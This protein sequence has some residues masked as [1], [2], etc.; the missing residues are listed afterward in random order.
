MAAVQEKMILNMAQGSRLRVQ[1][2]ILPIKSS[3]L[4]P[5]NLFFSITFI[6]SAIRT[7]GYSLAFK[8]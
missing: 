2:K 5:P 1:Y 4:F 3:L 8:F 7:K 6:L